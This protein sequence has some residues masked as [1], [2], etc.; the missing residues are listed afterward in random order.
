[1]TWDLLN[2]KA[3]KDLPSSAAKLLPYALGKPKVHMKNP[4]C[5]QTE[6][7]FTYSEGKRHGFASTTFS[8]CLDELVKKG[9][10]KPVH[11]GGLRGDGFSSSKYLLSLAWHTYGTNGHQPLI[12]RQEI[13]N[14]QV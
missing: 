11:K 6:F 14:G 4:A 5:Y 7:E 10:I 8:R 13:P 2:S 12:R 3:Y 1:M 9:F